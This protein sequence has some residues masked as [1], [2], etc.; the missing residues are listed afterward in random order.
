MISLDILALPKDANA[1]KEQTM[2]PR[3]PIDAD[4]VIKEPA[5]VMQRDDANG[6]VIVHCLLPLYTTKLYID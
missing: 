1:P 3:E 5:K 4:G 2:Q 6:L